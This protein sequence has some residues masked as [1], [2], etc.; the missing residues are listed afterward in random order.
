VETIVAVG[1]V[2]EVQPEAHLADVEVTMVTMETATA[3]VKA[4]GITNSKMVPNQRAGGATSMDTVKKTAANESKLTLHARASTVRPIG[5]NKKPHQSEKTKS[6]KKFKEQSV[7]KCIQANSQVC[8]RVFSKR[9]RYFPDLHPKNIFFNDYDVVF[10]A[11]AE[12]K[13]IFKEN[14]LLQWGIP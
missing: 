4:K 6:K 8:S 11:S 5:Q 1:D 10:Y 2:A 13:F 9:R 12:N 7:V 3:M 14:Y